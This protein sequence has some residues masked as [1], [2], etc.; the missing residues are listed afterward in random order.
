ML[1]RI[2]TREITAAQVIRAV[3]NNVRIDCKRVNQ[4]ATLGLWFELTRYCYISYYLSINCK[5]FVFA[6]YVLNS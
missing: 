6:F 3:Y 4:F 5:L 2:G 1:C